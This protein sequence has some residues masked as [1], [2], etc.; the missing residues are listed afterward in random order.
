MIRRLPLAAASV[1]V[2]A[3]LTSGCSTFTRNDAAAEVNGHELAIK[4]FEAILTDLGGV[5]DALGEF[6]GTGARQLLTAWVS[7]TALEDELASQGIIIDDAARQEAEQGLETADQASVDAGNAPQVSTWSGPTKALQVNY[8]AMLDAIA[9]S[10]D[11]IPESQLEAAYN[12]GHAASGVLC[13]RVMSFA[14]IT[15]AQDAFD[16][17]LS[18]AADFATLAE[19]NPIDPSIPANGGIFSDPTTGAECLSSASYPGL[20]DALGPS[21]VGEVAGPLTLGDSTIL[22]I[23]R[24]YGEVAE[25]LRP[26]LGPAIAGD[27]SRSL[28]S[29]IHANIDSRYGMWDDSVGQVVPAQ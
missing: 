11:L 17:L 13:L 22:F 29:G 7:L 24:P 26:I 1:A 21:N 27:L 3:L 9:A 12:A 16:D 20:G 18:G 8:R 10:D 14:S 19:D 23:E 28:V 4:D 15:E 25:Q 6:P 5:P 2:V